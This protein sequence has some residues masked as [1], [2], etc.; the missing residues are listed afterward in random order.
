MNKIQLELQQPAD[1]YSKRLITRN[2]ELL[3]D[4]C[5]RFYERQF[6]TRAKVNK[7]VL[8]KFE[9]LLDAYFQDEKPKHQGLPT[10]KYFAGQVNLS[11][12]YFGDLLKKETGKTAQEYIQ[13]KLIN[14]AKEEIIGSDKNVSEIANLLGFQYPQHFTRIFKKNVGYTPSE[15]RK[16]KIE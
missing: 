9:D 11:P 10:V 6:I 3:L 16:L 4:Y 8:T 2:I 5:M 13:E 15:Y 1:K 7:D 14:V 12:N